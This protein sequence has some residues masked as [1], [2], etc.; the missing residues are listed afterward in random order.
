MP[1]RLVNTHIALYLERKLLFLLWPQF[2]WKSEIL[3]AEEEAISVN[4]KSFHKIVFFLGAADVLLI[5]ELL[6]DWN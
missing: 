4:S 1:E 2:W 6:L 3:E 5:V